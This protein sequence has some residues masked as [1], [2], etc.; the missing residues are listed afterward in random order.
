MCNMLRKAKRWLGEKVV[1]PLRIKLYFLE[2]N[3]TR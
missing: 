3:L 1:K 2:L